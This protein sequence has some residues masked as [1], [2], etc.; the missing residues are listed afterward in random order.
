MS[1]PITTPYRQR[2]TMMILEATSELGGA[3]IQPT[4]AKMNGELLDYFPM[5]DPELRE[6]LR[7][8][9]LRPCKYIV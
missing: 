3:G 2:L 6:M 4:G 1:H 9:W 5:P 7:E 8:H